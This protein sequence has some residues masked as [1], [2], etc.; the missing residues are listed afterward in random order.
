MTTPFSEVALEARYQAGIRRHGLGLGEGM[1][2]FEKTQ[3]SP[4]WLPLS[5]QASQNSHLDNSCLG[6]QGVTTKQPCGSLTGR[7][8]CWWGCTGDRR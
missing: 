1:A 8:W 3:K 7:S 6:G 5:S 2:P 4:A